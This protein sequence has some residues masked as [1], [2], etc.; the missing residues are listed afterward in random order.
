MCSAR[1]LGRLGVLR[2]RNR[3]N[4]VRSDW[5]DFALVMNTK[6]RPVESVMTK[7]VPAK[8]RAWRRSWVRPVAIRSWSVFAADSR[9]RIEIS[10]HGV[11]GFGVVSDDCGNPCVLDGFVEL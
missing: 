5:R 3:R 1:L 8:M 4:R 11:S 9:P 6:T 10:E 7:T 2:R